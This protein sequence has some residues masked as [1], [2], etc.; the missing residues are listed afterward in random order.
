MKKHLF[1][2]LISAVLFA[3]QVEAQQVM[4]G[5]QYQAVA[6]DPFNLALANLPISLKISLIGD[7]HGDK[8]LY[9][10][11]HQATTDAQGLFSIIIGE[12]E[13]KSG[14]LS[15][16]PWDK[17]QVWLK[18]EMSGGDTKPYVI[19]SNNRLMSV[20][21][22]MHA[23]S[24]GSLAPKNEDEPIE[25]NQSIY[26]TT[27]GNSKTS[28]AT[29]FVGTR[30]AKDLVFKTNNSTWATLTKE[31]QL[32]YQ[33]GVDGE[34]TDVNNYPWVVQGSNQGIYIKVNGSRSY[35]NN[36]LTFADDFGTWGAVEGQTVAEM[37]DYWQYKLTV[38]VYALTGVSLTG[39]IVAWTAEGISLISS[40]LGAGAGVGALINS[41][42]LIINIAA[43]ISSATTWSTEMHNQVGVSYSSGAADYAEWLQRVDEERNLLFGEVV[44]VKAGKVSL[45]TNGAD[46]YRVVSKK[47]A[48]LGNAPSP[49]QEKNFEKV[50]FMGQVKVRIAGPAQIGDYIIP[51]GNNDG[52]G[53][54]IHPKNMKLGD[55]VR[56]V[57]V[58]WE[59]A[60]DAPINFIN[61]AIGINSNELAHKVELLE[62]KVQNIKGYLKG[63]NSLTAGQADFG[64][65]ALQKIQTVQQKLISDEEFDKMLDRNKD[66]YTDL[67][68]KVKQNLQEKGYDINANPLLVKFFE[69]PIEAIK[70]IRRD[71]QFAT[72]WAQ[73]DQ[74]LKSGR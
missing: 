39:Q 33:S 67:Y 65:A 30:D 27:S 23:A 35:D 45:N 5:F 58:A 8:I 20:P 31:G 73:V 74:K 53:I 57:G 55:Y 32:K 66:L 17:E 11:Q 71:P 50:A 21:Y 12:G 60:P 3:T 61:I 40:G 13:Q 36:F 42:V 62:Q 70:Q 25:K 51:S 1:F 68:A 24:A 34:D 72:Q 43:L 26:W 52:Y 59:S 41:G 2:L 37:E 64:S 56:I 54:A 28:P 29:H 38:A 48:V 10:E 49:E 14:L 6:R 4:P 18:V 44:G 47:P 9:T 19:L 22:A 15:A 69:N 63:Q 16:I 7:N 46:H